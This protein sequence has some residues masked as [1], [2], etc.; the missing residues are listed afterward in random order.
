MENMSIMTINEMMAH[1]EEVE[2]LISMIEEQENRKY[3]AIEKAVA[4]LE[5]EEPEGLAEIARQLDEI[6]K[7]ENRKYEAIERAVA[8]L[9]GEAPENLVEIANQFDKIEKRNAEIEKALAKMRL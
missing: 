2:E 1:A 6:E 9:E 7:C 8:Q 3:E 4:K 5:D